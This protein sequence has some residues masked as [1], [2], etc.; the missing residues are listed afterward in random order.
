MI[1]TLLYPMNFGWAR[2]DR[3][4][5]FDRIMIAQAMVEEMPF[6]SVDKVFDL[7]PIERVW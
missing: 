3:R 4:D 5:S 1:L 6:L 2:N 7:Y